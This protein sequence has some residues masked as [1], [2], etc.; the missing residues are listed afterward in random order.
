MKFHAAMSALLR[1]SFTASLLLLGACA[2]VPSAGIG[3]DDKIPDDGG[4]VAVQVV[5]NSEKL[6][7]AL[8]NWTEVIVVDLDRAKPDGTHLIY[9]LP[10]LNNGLSSTRVFVGVLRPGRYR[11]AGLYAFAQVGDRMQSQNARAPETIGSF[12]IATDQM[13]NLGTVLFQPFPGDPMS[14]PMIG[15]DM[16]FAYAMSR[17]DDRVALEDFV[18]HSYPAR[19]ERTR[20]HAPLGWLPDSLGPL[21]DQLASMI[22]S[23]AVLSAAYQEPNHGDIYYAAR[24][25]TLYRR[26]EGGTWTSAH[27][28]T[29]YDLIAFAHLPDGSF[30][31]GGERGTIWRAREFTG[32]WQG[33]P[34]A[35]RDQ[36]VIWLGVI[37]GQ[38][39]AVTST[40][41]G[42][43]LYKAGGSEAR[44]GDWQRVAD[45]GAHDG[46]D[47]QRRVFA[48]E[49]PPM[50][51]RGPH[52]LTLFDHKSRHRF[53]TRSGQFTTEPGDGLAAL[54]NQANGIVV[55]MP[56]SGWMGSKPP[57]VSRDG[58]ASWESYQ[59]LGQFHEPPY[60]F[61]DGTELGIDNDASFMLIGWQRRASIDV[62]SSADKG[63]TSTTVGHVSYG[64]GR[65]EG[66]ISTDARLFARCRDGTL[67]M[68]TDKGRTW[69]RDADRTPRRE[70]MPREFIADPASGASTE[71]R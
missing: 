23:R 43:R 63:A 53:D 62:L 13:T 32:P 37:E 28:P 55:A 16:R 45:Y 54:V 33:E 24:L 50:L 30:V 68:S 39:L 27:L 2:T 17:L 20:A 4:L 66:A 44:P 34:L 57:I 11:F 35:D 52:G 25:G 46:Y 9:S 59:R 36:V 8:P 12:E 69:T 42:Y 1:L 3:R 51:I 60:V 48:I 26:D 5:T 41:I 70:K 14:K 58:G 29:E 10:A 19:Y 64:C 7:D 67:L 38:L 31:A 22:R 21:R 6:S 47:E 15:S 49:R 40:G 65:L 56:H 18:A 61:E 71:A